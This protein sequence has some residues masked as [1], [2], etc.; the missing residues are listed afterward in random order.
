[1]SCQ[2]QQICGG[3]PYRN[4]DF[5]D[6]KKLKIEQ[7]ER[8]LKQI[9]QDKIA[10]GEAVF[11]ADG[12]RRRAELAFKHNRGNLVLGF[13]ESKSHEL[14]NVEECPLL[15]A[16]INSLIPQLRSFLTEFCNIKVS[17]KL[18]NKKFRTYNIG[19]GDI[20]LTEAVNGVDMLLEINESL[21][22]EHRMALCDFANGTA[23]IGRA[24]V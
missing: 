2:Y 4:L 21:S 20:W 11:V 6:Y 22:L 9:N 13:N 19:S 14:I 23:E 3:C 7:F 16:K 24:H 15:T 12:T 18:K 8:V 5:A 10:A 1:M 17:E